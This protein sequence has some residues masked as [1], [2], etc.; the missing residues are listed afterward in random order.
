MNQSDRA[1][2]L[3]GRSRVLAAMLLGSC[4]STN[5]APCMEWADVSGE[6]QIEVLEPYS[7]SVSDDVR[8]FPGWPQPAYTCGS[9]LDVV[10]GDVIGAKALRTVVIDPD[11]NCGGCAGI[12]IEARVPGV[13]FLDGE[14]TPPRSL[15]AFG[16]T[17][18]VVID[19]DC[20]GTYVLAV[21]KIADSFVDAASS[22]VASDYMLFREF[23]ARPGECGGRYQDSCAD[24]FFARIR[25]KDGRLVSDDK[26]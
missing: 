13:K 25:T 5:E 3:A 22:P 2:R 16:V 23:R 6:Y 19:D 8:P 11:T 10:V 1:W 7:G 17:G 18:D 24:A 4:C 9:D 15:E 26:S 21:T 14:Q 12:L 20:V